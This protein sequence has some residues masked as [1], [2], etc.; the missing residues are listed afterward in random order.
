VSDDVGAGDSVCCC[1]AMVATIIARR[2]TTTV[3]ED[4]GRARFIVCFCYSIYYGKGKGGGGRSQLAKCFG[5]GMH[6]GDPKRVI[7]Y[8]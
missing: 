6:C 4:I 7:L 8:I 2:R 5:E 3:R 1:A